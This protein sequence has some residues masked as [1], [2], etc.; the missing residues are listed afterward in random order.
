MG[1]Q[2]MILGKFLKGS[3]TSPSF[4]GQIFLPFVGP[5]KV[6]VISFSQYPTNASLP[7]P[8]P[9]NKTKAPDQLRWEDDI[10]PQTGG[11]N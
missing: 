2:F 3:Y 9:W 7:N 6:L 11:N 10:P 8:T 5:F 1:S 4:V